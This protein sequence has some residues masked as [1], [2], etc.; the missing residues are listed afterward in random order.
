MER[1]DVCTETWGILE[2]DFSTDLGG[3]EFPGE[4]EHLTHLQEVSLTVSSTPL[5]EEE[6]ER[7]ERRRERER[8]KMHACRG[9][10]TVGC[11]KCSRHAP[12]EQG[13]TLSY[14]NAEYTPY[15]IHYYCGLYNTVP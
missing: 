8:E 4:Y 7:Q 6:G 3:E 15:C 1:K 11:C 10:I 14:H 2:S 5:E 13:C 12:E 9:L